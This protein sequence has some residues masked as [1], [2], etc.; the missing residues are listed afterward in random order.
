MHGTVCAYYSQCCTPL[1]SHDVV[2]NIRVSNALCL[3]PLVFSSTVFPIALSSGHR[4]RTTSG[5]F[6]SVRVD[7]FFT[8]RADVSEFCD[9]LRQRTGFV[10]ILR[11]KD[12]VR[13]KSK[14]DEI[15][16]R[17]QTNE[18]LGELAVDISVRHRN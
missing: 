13:K 12:L 14:T 17:R 2:E 10:V 18:G 3:F 7:P 9:A 5:N 11:N 1:Q 6:V 16:I 15:L 4:V 8:T